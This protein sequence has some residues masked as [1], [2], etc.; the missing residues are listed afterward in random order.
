MERLFYIPGDHPALVWAGDELSRLGQ[1]VT[2]EPSDQV[3]HLLLGVPCKDSE[4]A[5]SELLFKLPSNITWT[6]RFYP[7]I[8]AWIC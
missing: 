8:G 4:D 3:T 7:A 5:L 2:K 6:K 1:S